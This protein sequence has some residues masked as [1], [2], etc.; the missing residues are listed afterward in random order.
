MFQTLEGW[1][2]GWRG[3]TSRTATGTESGEEEEN[4]EGEDNKWMGEDI[5]Y[6][7]LPRVLL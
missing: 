4:E 6:T 5:E 1:S 3:A 7:H 2:A